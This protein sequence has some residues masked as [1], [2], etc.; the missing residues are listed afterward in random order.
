VAEA[1]GGSVRVLNTSVGCRFEMRVP[2][3]R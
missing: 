1:H 2:A 3:Y